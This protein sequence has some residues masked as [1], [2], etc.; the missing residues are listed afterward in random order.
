MPP[1]VSR[2][3]IAL[4]LRPALAAPILPP[5]PKLRVGGSI[6]LGEASGG[7]SEKLSSLRSL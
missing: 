5:V 3:Q 1:N 2:T 4:R 6:P 7:E